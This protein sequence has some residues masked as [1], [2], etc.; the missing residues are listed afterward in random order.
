MTVD[1]V[2]DPTMHVGALVAETV[3]LNKVKWSATATVTIT[4]GDSG[5]DGV[6]CSPLEV[7]PLRAERG[8]SFRLVTPGVR[9]AGA[10]V[11]DQKR[12]MT[13][14]DAIR[15]GASYLVMG[16]GDVYTF[17]PTFR[18]ENSNTPRHVAEFWMIEPEM[19]FY[20]LDAN[21][22]LAEDFIQNVLRYVLEHCMEDL[23][24]LEKR[25]LD[26]EKSKPHA[27]RSQLPLIE[28]LR[29]VTDQPFTRVTCT[30]AFEILR[31]S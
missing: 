27:E 3:R 19:A 26:E 16:L 6:V 15:A 29:F 9:P 13:P 28:K 14:G 1:N 30:E 24:F 21:M 18:A 10:A 5:L 25:L 20:D 4:D 22:D 7:V 31:N 11:D 17:G 12:I 8:E 23:E 2:A